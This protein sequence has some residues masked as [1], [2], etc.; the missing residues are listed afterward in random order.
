M[1][2]WI[3]WLLRN[4]RLSML[5]KSLLHFWLESCPEL[6]FSVQN[7]VWNNIRPPWNLEKIS[8]CLII[9]IF[10]QIENGFKFV[11]YL[12]CLVFILIF[13]FPSVP[14]NFLSLVPI[15]IK[16]KTIIIPKQSTRINNLATY[17]T[18]KCFVNMLLFQNREYLTKMFS[19]I[20]TNIP[21][22]WF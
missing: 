18:Y 6:L 21:K 5:E 16:T 15:N 3:W 13:N 8:D 9:D 17:L 2:L 12:F 22:I 19:T 7:R 11:Y 20:Q 1:Y 14:P 4:W 10:N